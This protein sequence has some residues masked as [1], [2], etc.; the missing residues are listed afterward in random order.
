MSFVQEVACN[1]DYPRPPRRS[2]S[3]ARLNASLA[4]STFTMTGSKP[5]DAAH[6]RLPDSHRGARGNNRRRKGSGRRRAGQGFGERDV[7]ENEQFVEV[8]GKY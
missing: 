8:G 3:A 1:L 2:R 5:G 4:R 6:D 7:K